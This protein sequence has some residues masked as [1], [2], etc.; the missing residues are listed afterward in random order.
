MKLFKDSKN[1]IYAYE[2]DGSQDHLIDGKT[3]I[4]KAEADEII[5]VKVEESI[6]IMS[7]AEQRVKEYPPIG[8]QLDMLW[9]AIDNNTLDKTSNFYLTLKQVKDQYPKT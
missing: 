5:R 7:Y 8:D 6:N 9:H 1:N 4:T 2:E 3:P